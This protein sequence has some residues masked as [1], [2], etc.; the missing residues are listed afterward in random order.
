MVKVVLKREMHLY[1]GIKRKQFIIMSILKN[2][3]VIKSANHT[4]MRQASYLSLRF[5]LLALAAR[6]GM[7]SLLPFC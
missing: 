4:T 7:E 6:P 2:A 5:V 1:F 3:N